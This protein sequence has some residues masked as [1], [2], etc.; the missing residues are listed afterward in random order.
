[1][2]FARQEDSATISTTEYSLVNDSTSLAAS[3]EEA[4]VSLWLDVSALAAGDE[5]E[6]RVYEKVMAGGTQ[7]LVQAPWVLNGAQASPIWTSPALHLANGWDFTL[8]RT[9]GSDRSITWSIRKVA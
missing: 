4:A 9:A 1:M 5:F 3:T 8:K 6:I 2:G 7:R